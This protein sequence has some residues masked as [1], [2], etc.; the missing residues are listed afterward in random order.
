LRPPRLRIILDVHHLVRRIPMRDFLALDLLNLPKIMLL[1]IGTIFF[2]GLVMLPLL[3]CGLAAVLALVDHFD[4][5]VAELLVLRSNHLDEAV[6]P[7]FW[8]DIHRL[9]LT[10]AGFGLILCAII[11]RDL[12]EAAWTLED[13]AEDGVSGRGLAAAAVATGL[14]EPIDLGLDL[15]PD[16]LE[17]DPKLIRV[18]RRT[19]VLRDKCGG[20]AAIDG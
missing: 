14:V 19:M 4:R 12:R 9:G 16:L 3:S 10:G 7:A 20:G 1:E 6:G 8:A 11:E 13:L 2:V 18:N 15:V 17:S 5:Y